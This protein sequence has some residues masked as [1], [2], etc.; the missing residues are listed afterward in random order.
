MIKVT[1]NRVTRTDNEVLLTHLSG[2][3]NHWNIQEVIKG[4]KSEFWTYIWDSVGETFSP[5]R[6]NG[7]DFTFKTFEAALEAAMDYSTKYG[8]KTCYNAA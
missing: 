2:I 4:G 7:K 1:R 6:H 5:V 3:E 8:D